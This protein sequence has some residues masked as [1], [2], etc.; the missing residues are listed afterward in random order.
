MLIKVVTFQRKQL[1]LTVAFTIVLCYYF[2]VYS[3]FLLRNNYQD[4]DGNYQCENM[5]QCALI[6]I[7]MGLTS[8]GGLGSYL[9]NQGIFSPV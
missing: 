3:F 4:E 9:N 7:R 6:T 1:F 5:M 8:D 2:S